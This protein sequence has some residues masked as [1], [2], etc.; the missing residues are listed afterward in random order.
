M[1]QYRDFTIDSGRSGYLTLKKPLLELYPCLLLCEIVFSELPTERGEV[2]R[3]S[4]AQK[5]TAFCPHCRPRNYGLQRSGL[6][7]SCTGILYSTCEVSCV[8][9]LFLYSNAYDIYLV[10]RLWC[11]RERIGE[12]L[13]RERYHWGELLRSGLAWSHTF[14]GFLQSRNPGTINYLVRDSIHI[15]YIYFLTILNKCMYDILRVTGTINWR[16]STTWW[17]TMA[18]GSTWTRSGIS[19]LSYKL[20]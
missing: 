8:F 14:S 16:P 11:V 19:S 13:V 5:R 6:L 4:I 17:S 15:F 2:L 3:G 10:C 12:R 18:S 1:E 7:P 20:T 9:Y